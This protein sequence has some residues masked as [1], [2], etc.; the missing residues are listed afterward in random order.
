MSRLHMGVLLW[1]SDGGL[2]G[3][4]VHAADNVQRQEPGGAL[5][6]TASVEPVC[7]HDVSGELTEEANVRSRRSE[8]VRV[9]RE[10]PREDV[11]VDVPL[12]IRAEMNGKGILIVESWFPLMVCAA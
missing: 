9:E 11:A 12:C 10:K 4:R 1:L 3:L 6:Y 7:V 2:T 5:S 8:R